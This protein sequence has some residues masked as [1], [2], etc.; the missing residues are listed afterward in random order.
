LLPLITA[1]SILSLVPSASAGLLDSNDFDAPP[2]LAPGITASGFTNGTLVA[3]NAFG[4][5]LG[6]SFVNRSQGNPASTSTL[7][8]SNL[9]DHIQN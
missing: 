1:A 6:H 2:S 7:T 9:P 5:W 4:A 8:L 3:A